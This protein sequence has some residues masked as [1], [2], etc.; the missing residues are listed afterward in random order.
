MLV[1]SAGL[2]GLA[3]L[4]Q[5]GATFTTGNLMPNRSLLPV[6]AF[7]GACLVG[8]G[9]IFALGWDS[10]ARPLPQPWFAPPGWVIGVV[11]LVLFALMGLVYG[12]LRQVKSSTSRTMIALAAACLAYPLYT[13]GLQNGLV[14]LIG[15]IVTLAVTLGLMGYLKRI[16][17]RSAVLL[18]PMTVWLVFASILTA[19][20]LRV[21]V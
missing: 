8:N 6:L 11:W 10:G 21:H 3:T 14:G 1:R 13:G 7:T 2:A 12:R 19:T 20:I 18:V 9:V 5:A 17:R 4:A 15:N 16:D